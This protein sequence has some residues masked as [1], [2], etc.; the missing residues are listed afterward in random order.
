MDCMNNGELSKKCLLVPEIS[1]AV[2]PVTVH[3]LN[4]EDIN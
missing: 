1:P 3:T 4:Q 2:T